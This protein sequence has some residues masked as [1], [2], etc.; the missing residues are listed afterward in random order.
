MTH[1]QRDV[2]RILKSHGWRLTNEYGDGNIN[3]TRV[4]PHTGDDSDVPM[5]FVDY[6]GQITKPRT[7]NT[8]RAHIELLDIGFTVR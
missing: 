5:I 1:H 8:M 6:F 2:V 4:I 7:L 3:L